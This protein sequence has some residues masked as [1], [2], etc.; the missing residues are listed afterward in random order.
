MRLRGRLIVL[1]CVSFGARARLATD[2]GALT[3]IELVALRGIAAGLDDVQSLSQLVGLGQRPT[4]DLIYDF[5]LKGYVVVDAARAR[6]R[7][8]GAAEAANRTDGLATLATAENNLEVVPLIQELVSGAV[9]PHLG[10]PHPI[11]AESALVPV[12]RS[13][14]SLDEVNRGEVLDAV[15][16]EVERQGRKLG[17]PLV[18]QEAWIEP[19]QLLTEAA[20]GSSFVPQRR[21]LPALADIEVD[22]DSGRMLFRI[23]EAA[24]VPPPVCRNIER[25]LSLLAERMPEQLFFKRLRQEFERSPLDSDPTERDSAVERLCRAA[26]AVRVKW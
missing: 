17:R 14:L 4:L 13:G 26:S 18:A 19:D 25:N 11:G 22:P 20:T 3:P 12:S 15:K 24:E 8:A 1:P 16:R 9:L 5:W 6:V 21:F 23:I 7:L 10:R 2:S